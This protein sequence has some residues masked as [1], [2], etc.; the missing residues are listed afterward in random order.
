M[1]ATRHQSL[2]RL[3]LTGGIATGK[4]TVANRWQDAGAVVVDSDALAHQTLAPD[5]PTWAEVARVFG[6]AVLNSDQTVNRRRLGEIVFHD[7]AK[8]QELNQIIH[9]AV[10]RLWT[11]ELDRLTREGRTAVAVVAIPL[12]YE[13]A[14]EKEFDYV[15]A[16]GCSEPTQLAR[17]AAKGLDETQAR[18]RIRAQLPMQTKLDRADFVIWN[19]GTLPV[20]DRQADIIWQTIKE[21]HHAPTQN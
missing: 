2:I 10:R 6:A 15:V 7:E 1:D 13:V 17:L 12:L 18:A 11:A 19:D 8:R 4:S 21:T 16:V 14:A 9:P 3:G 20:L 5:T